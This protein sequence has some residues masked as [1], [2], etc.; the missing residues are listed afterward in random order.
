DLLGIGVTW[1]PETD[2]W[3]PRFVSLDFDIWMVGLRSNVPDP[4]E[5]SDILRSKGPFNPGHY[6]NK[7]LDNLYDSILK[8]AIRNEQYYLYEQI[9]NHMMDEAPF[10]QIDSWGIIH[11]IRKDFVDYISLGYSNRY[12]FKYLSVN[13]TNIIS[14]A[15]ANDEKNVYFSRLNLGITKLEDQDFKVQKSESLS[16]INKQWEIQGDEVFGFSFNQLDTKSMYQ[17]SI[18]LEPDSTLDF[19]EIKVYSIENNELREIQ[20]TKNAELLAIE[21]ETTGDKFISVS[22]GA[23]Q[24]DILPKPQNSSFLSS[25]WGIVITLSLSIFVVLGV[26]IDYIR[27]N[28]GKYDGFRYN[29]ERYRLYLPVK[30]KILLSILSGVLLT[31]GFLLLNRLAS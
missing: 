29:I 17:T 24:L 27:K 16:N 26:S 23:L 10:L 21:F 13:K 8:T 15:I 1:E 2:E 25:G 11:P 4:F 31:L 6:S 3:I 14:S 9:A 5:F 22:N 28:V 7:T 20:F 18:F 19:E 30:S 12:S